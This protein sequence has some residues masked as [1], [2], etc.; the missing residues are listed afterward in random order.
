M[1]ASLLSPRSPLALLCLCS[2]TLSLYP[3]CLNSLSSPE[4]SLYPPLASLHPKS[5]W[6]EGS[7]CNPQHHSTPPLSG[8]WSVCTLACVHLI[9]WLVWGRTVR[10]SSLASLM[11]SCLI[12]LP[13]QDCLWTNP[14][15]YSEDFHHCS[16]TFW[17]PIRMVI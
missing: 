3:T 15:S 12:C 1:E 16:L 10:A 11:C 8:A 13:L 2:P 7:L 6:T 5:L 9:R 14:V 4:A 17:L